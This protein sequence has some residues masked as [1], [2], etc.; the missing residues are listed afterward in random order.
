MQPEDRKPP[1]LG[2]QP[3]RQSREQPTPS[4]RDS[5]VTTAEG[6]SHPSPGTQDS[7]VPHA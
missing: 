3:D 4:T 7:A 1:R 5:A 2:R 6:G